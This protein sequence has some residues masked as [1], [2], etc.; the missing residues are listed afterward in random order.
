MNFMG[1]ILF[2]QKLGINNKFFNKVFFLFAF[3]Y[4]NLLF[5]SFEYLQAFRFLSSKHVILIQAYNNLALKKITVFNGWF[6]LDDSK[7]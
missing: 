6:S 3:V 4:N 5:G 1:N 2:K 7:S